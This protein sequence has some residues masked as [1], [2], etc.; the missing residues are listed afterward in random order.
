VTFPASANG[1]LESH[2][3][4][5]D[6]FSYVD[7]DGNGYRILRIDYRGRSPYEH[8]LDLATVSTE[9]AQQRGP[10]F[11]MTLA[12]DRFTE[13]STAAIKRYVK[14]V[15]PRVQANAIIAPHG[16][17]RAFL[18]AVWSKAGRP[19][20]PFGDEYRALEWLRQLPG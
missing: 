14:E 1:L 9:I 20:V 19:C 3:N 18:M 6:L 2:D 17:R 7:D 16:F 13:G 15:A 11:L 8:T 5:R 10:L 12:S 4:G